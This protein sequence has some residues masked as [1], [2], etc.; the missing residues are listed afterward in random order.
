[1]SVGNYERR[2]GG[3]DRVLQ[4]H[5]F[6]ALS[7]LC[8]AVPQAAADQDVPVDRLTVVV[9]GA[10]GS[11]WDELAHAMQRV[12]HSNHLVRT[13]EIANAPGGGGTAGL[14]Q[15]V[16]AHR[17][18]GQALLVGGVSLVQSVA[19]N[20][21]IIA[22]H[23]AT[24]IA[25]LTGEIE[26]IAVPTGSDPQSLDGLVQ[27]LGSNPHRLPRV[28]I[29]NLKGEAVDPSLINW[30]GIFAPPGI[31]AE[32]QAVLIGIVG[33]MVKTSEWQAELDRYHWSDLY[34]PGDAFG[35]FV[36]DEEARTARLAVPSLKVPPGKI[37][38]SQMWLLRN[39][40]SLAMAIAAVMLLA[41]GYIV[42]QRKTAA[43]R[44]RALF[45]QLEIAQE[46]A[47]RRGA[48]A[49]ELARGL[50]EQIDRQLAKW[51]LTT[52]EHEV[53]LLMLKGLRHKEIADLRGTSERTVRQQ[54]ATIY[55]K[56]GIGGRT[57]LAAFFMEDF[58]QPSSVPSVPTRANSKTIR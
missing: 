50:S 34:L 21:S 26:V 9:P 27:A 19:A 12:L 29:S 35:Q 13:V 39:R 11:G 18:D 49:E 3:R 48:E 4:L 6:M 47:E 1:M 22:L 43:Q 8:I 40:M 32:Q 28:A 17:G 33:R 15:F 41:A 46:T 7:M 53:A 36:K 45:H 51:G 38:A 57:D 52:A 25:R 24:A 14:A 30:R 2:S 23:Q 37:L 56:A 20:H 10:R 58:L 42:W 55:K 54:A 31:S 16:T 5:L 44:A